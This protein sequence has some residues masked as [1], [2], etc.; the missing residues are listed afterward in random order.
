MKYKALNYKLIFDNE[1]LIY[2]VANFDCIVWCIMTL[3]EHGVLLQEG[4]D[5]KTELAVT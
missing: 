5:F 4:F 3:A 2:S 1:D